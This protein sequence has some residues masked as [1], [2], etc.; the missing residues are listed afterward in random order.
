VF[1][2]SALISSALD[3]ADLR[4][5]DHFLANT[6]QNRSPA[7]RSAVVEV[8][9]NCTARLDAGLVDLDVLRRRAAELD[10][11]PAAV[12]RRVEE[13]LGARARWEADDR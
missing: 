10:C 4:L 12:Q 8:M 11:V 3:R 5:R 9:L 1:A 6:P 2:E 13:W 7:R